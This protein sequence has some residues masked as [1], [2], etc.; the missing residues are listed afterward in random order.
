VLQD[1]QAGVDSIPQS[2]NWGDEFSQFVSNIAGRSI[3]DPYTLNYIAELLAEN[4]EVIASTEGGLAASVFTE[5]YY[6]KDSARILSI[7]NNDRRLRVTGKINPAYPYDP[8]NSMCVFRKVPAQKISDS[9][10]IRI[11]RVGRPVSRDRPVTIY[12]DLTQVH[13]YIRVIACAPGKFPS[14]ADFNRYKDANSTQGRGGGWISLNQA[15]LDKL[16]YD[17]WKF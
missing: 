17:F 7:S 12:T 3:W 9:L 16:L 4:G 6:W 2:Q 10:T 11:T 1:V 13:D 15:Q 14:A 8:L 5:I